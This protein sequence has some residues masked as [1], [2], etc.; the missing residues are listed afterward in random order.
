[1]KEIFDGAV[2]T[3]KFGVYIAEQLI[4][5][6][7]TWATLYPNA[8]LQVRGYLASLVSREL[9]GRENTTPHLDDQEFD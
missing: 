7:K 5:T 6:A 9:M 4:I 2:E 8:D 1:V 3:P